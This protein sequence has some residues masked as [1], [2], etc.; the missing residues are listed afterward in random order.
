MHSTRSKLVNRGHCFALG[1]NQDKENSKACF[2]A[3]KRVKVDFSLSP[4]TPHPSTWP[5]SFSSVCFFPLSHVPWAILWGKQALSPSAKPPWINAGHCR[6]APG[7]H[8]L[9]S[10]MALN[11]LVSL[12]SIHVLLF[13][14]LTFPSV[15]IYNFLSA[16]ESSGLIIWSCLFYSWFFF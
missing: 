15:A 5:E 11:L 9:I 4:P 16:S 10:P 14:Y 2:E 1:K 8:T 6:C 13:A 12:V 3:S 7:K